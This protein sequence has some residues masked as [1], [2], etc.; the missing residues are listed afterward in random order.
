MTDK[1]IRDGM[2]AVIVSPGFGAGWS[3]WNDGEDAAWCRHDPELVAAIEAGDKARAET[4]AE[5]RNEHIYTGGLR[6]AR[7]EWV[8]LGA[9]YYIHEYDGNE[10]IV[11]DFLTA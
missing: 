9:P 6:D 1:V 5:M 7:V 4:L 10:W 8:P 11:S 3:T 2:V